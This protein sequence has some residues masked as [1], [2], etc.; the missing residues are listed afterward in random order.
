MDGKIC[1]SEIEAAY[2]TSEKSY[3]KLAEQY[4][5]PLRTVED[6]GKKGNWVQKRRNHGETIME[7][8]L[9]ADREQALQRTE[10]LMQA[11][12]GLLDKVRELTAVTDSPAALKTLTE[13]LKNIRDA[14]MLKEGRQEG[15]RLTVVL[16]GVEGYAA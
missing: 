4:G 3:R 5:V 14:Q 7:D 13:A 6:R 8:I 15:D 9:K 2:V 11:G 12:D 1:W 16:E 10:R